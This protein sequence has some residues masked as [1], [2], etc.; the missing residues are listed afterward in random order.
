MKSNKDLDFI[1]AFSKI[2]IKKICEDLKIDKSNLW[3]GRTSS[4]NIKLVKEEIIKRINDLI[5]GH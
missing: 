1:K 5:K 3:A 2:N 4:Q